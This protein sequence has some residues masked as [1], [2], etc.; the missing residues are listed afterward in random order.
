MLWVVA[1]QEQT[2]DGKLD[3][4]TTSES[5]ESLAERMAWWE[6]ARFGMFIH[7][8]LYAVPAGEWK[9]QRVEGIGEWIMHRLGIPI[10]EYEQFAASF[11]PVAY[12]P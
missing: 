9:G 6:D 8:G 1:C 2:T 7:W 4:A 12:D 5:Q 10:D 3:T 11:N